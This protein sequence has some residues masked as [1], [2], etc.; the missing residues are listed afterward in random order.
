MAAIARKAL[1]YTAICVLDPYLLSF[2]GGGMELGLNSNQH[3]I[4]GVD[5][6]TC[7]KGHCGVFSRGNPWTQKHW[8]TFIHSPGFPF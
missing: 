1:I 3:F 5:C 6:T 4:A 8:I 2:P 7:F